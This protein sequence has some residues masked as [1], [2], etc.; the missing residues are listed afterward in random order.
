MWHISLLWEYFQLMS[1]SIK[2]SLSWEFGLSFTCESLIVSVC[3]CDKDILSSETGLGVP[4]TRHVWRISDALTQTDANSNAFGTRETTVVESVYPSKSA[5]GRK[6]YDDQ[7]VYVLD[8]WSYLR[9]QNTSVI[10]VDRWMRWWKLWNLNPV[11][12]SRRIVNLFCLLLFKN[13]RRQIATEM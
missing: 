3:T 12:S 4:S 8:A 9:L 7:V 13:G 1:D 2:C 5:T 10:H 11:H 6:R